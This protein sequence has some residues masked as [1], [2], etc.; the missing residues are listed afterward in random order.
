MI[1][2]TGVAKQ[3]EKRRF[4]KIYQLPQNQ[5]VFHLRVQGNGGEKIHYKPESP[6][7]GC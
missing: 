2:W 3:S 6:Q 5:K 7:E 4:D 1:S